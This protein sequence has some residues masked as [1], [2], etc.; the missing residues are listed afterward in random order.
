MESLDYYRQIPMRL[1]IM[2]DRKTGLFMA[3]Y[4]E[5]PGYVAYGKT[6]REAIKEAEENKGKWYS[7]YNSYQ[8]EENKE[9]H[10][11]IASHEHD[12]IDQYT[13]DRRPL[14]VAAYIR[15]VIPRNG[16]RSPIVL[17]RYLYESMISGHPG[18]VLVD[19]YI[20]TGNAMPLKDR[21]GLSR[22][23]RDC[24]SGKV[25][26]IIC[27]NSFRLFRNS[28]TLIELIHNLAE[29]DPPVGVY[30]EA[31]RTFSLALLSENNNDLMR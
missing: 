28:G 19:T 7:D 25:D 4:L 16:L 12:I 1:E 20:D 6:M 27:K 8:I 18:W 22:L 9:Q 29:F 2:S 13:K 10:H 24:C 17:Q 11:G 26:V 31:E 23:L 15:E 14:R 3:S 5:L 30:F 21:P